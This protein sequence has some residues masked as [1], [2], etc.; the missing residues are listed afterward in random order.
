MGP[1][2][3]APTAQCGFT[4][5]EIM[6]ALAI[7]AVAFVAL[8]G[9]R[10]SDIVMHDRARAMIQATALAQQRLGDTVVGPFPEIGSSEGRF[11]DDH[12]GYAWRQDVAATPFDFVREVRVS[13]T[14][15]PAQSERVD[16][17]RYV[18]QKPAG[19]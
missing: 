3:S 17:V 8:L 10:N 6:I 19:R 13:V 9:L 14:W 7:I 1:S 5:L 4:L 18:F 15:A 16:L 11:D 2:D 12:A